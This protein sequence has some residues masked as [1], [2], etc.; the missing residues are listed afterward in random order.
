MYVSVCVRVCVCVCVRVG[1]CVCRHACPYLYT[2]MF[3][4][5]Y[6]CMYAYA[7]VYVCVPVYLS[8]FNRIDNE[9]GSVNRKYKISLILL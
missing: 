9:T 4:L 1:G 8:K 3:T 2:G 6:M 5:G 7:Y